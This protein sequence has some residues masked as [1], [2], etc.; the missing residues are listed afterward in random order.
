MKIGVL[1]KAVP[2][3]EARIKIDNSGK[4][5]DRSDIKFVPNPYDEY[6]YEEALKLHE[7]IG[8]GEVVAISLCGDEGKDILKKS[9]LAVGCHRAIHIKS[10]LIYDGVQ[11]ADILKR[12]IEEEKFDIVFAG[13]Q[14]IDFDQSMVPFHIASSLNWPIVTAITSFEI[15][16]GKD[17]IVVKRAS[18]DGTEVIECSLPAIVTTTKGLNEP[19]YAKLKGIMAAK[20]K[21]MDEKDPASIST[22][23]AKS[24]IL[25]VTT[26]P[27][28]KPPKKVDGEFPEN[29]SK[30]VE[31]LRN[32]AK[33]I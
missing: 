22:M 25:K 12:V 26:P 2:D 29:V 23:G 6:A 31:L 1:I 32:E 3:T 11:T 24:E 18:E 28:R 14:A 4:G 9:A 16:E 15:S 10:D 13:K 21:P 5:I 20:K 27:S 19:R 33:V 7:K 30:L 8:E 17:S